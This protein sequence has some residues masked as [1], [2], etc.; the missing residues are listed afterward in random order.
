MGAG[1]GP[2][3]LERRSPP[4]G[5]PA[6][7]KF[8]QP[9]SADNG[10]GAGG[11]RGRKYSVRR[12]SLKVRVSLSRPTGGGVANGI[13]ASR[14]TWARPRFS[15]LAHLG[16]RQQ[17]GA[18]PPSASAASSPQRGC[19][20][21]RAR[22]ACGARSASRADSGCRAGSWR[23]RGGPPSGP[24]QARQPRPCRGRRSAPG[25]SP[26]AADPRRHAGMFPFEAIVARFLHIDHFDEITCRNSTSL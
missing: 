3:R 14:E 11:S 25:S 26:T 18:H 23:R 12:A 19:V 2:S 4:R 6:P 5:S 13:A 24:A 21:V 8:C 17:P 20:A 22:A 16:S 1:A 9:R 10:Q 15:V 7:A